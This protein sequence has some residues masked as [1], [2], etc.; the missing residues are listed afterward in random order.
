MLRGWLWRRWM[1]ASIHNRRYIKQ[2]VSV[3]YQK[4]RA[5]LG[6]RETLN[7]PNGTQKQVAHI[8]A[9]L[10]HPWMELV[11]ALSLFRYTLS[12]TVIL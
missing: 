5:C 10:D 6:Y 8:K 12:E 2:C 3:L 7:E 9:K 11:L 1:N 4:V